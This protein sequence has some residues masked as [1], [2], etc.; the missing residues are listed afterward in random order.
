MSRNRALLEAFALTGLIALIGIGIWAYL[1]LPDSIA[2]SFGSDGSVSYGSKTSVLMLPL[3]GVF[4]YMVTA[5]ESGAA[6]PRMSPIIPFAITDANREH[7]YAL[8][9]QLELVMKAM[10]PVGFAC[11][12]WQVVLS[13]RGSLSAGFV[14]TI[15]AFSVV[16]VGTILGYNVAMLRAR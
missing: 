10:L 7:I 13:A 2:T 6:R 5:F 15:V 1:R 12:E 4:A 11:I 3:L 9:R 8:M 14:P 16:L